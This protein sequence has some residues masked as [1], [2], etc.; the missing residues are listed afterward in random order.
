ME[1]FLGVLAVMG[2]FVLIIAGACFFIGLKMGTII[3]MTQGWNCTKSEIIGVEPSRYEVCRQYT[4][5]KR[6]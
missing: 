3:L 2:V 5:E 6:P 1:V 4:Q